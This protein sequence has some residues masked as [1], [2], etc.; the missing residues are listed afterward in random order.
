MKFFKVGDSLSNLVIELKAAKQSNKFGTMHYCEKIRL[1]T[2]VPIADYN[3]WTS[4]DGNQFLCIRFESGLRDALVSIIDLIKQKNGN[5]V[6]KEIATDVLYVKI[7]PEV[8]ST[9]PPNKM[10]NVVIEIF[11]VFQS[12]DTA[13]LQMDIIQAQV[14]QN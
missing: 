14:I 2:A 8:A 3:I 6:F 12:G 10:I 7:K 5:M 4:K 13:H 9:I 11:G 1:S